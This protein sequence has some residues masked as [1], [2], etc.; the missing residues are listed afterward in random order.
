ML[1]K[2]T[3]LSPRLLLVRRAEQAPLSSGSD[4]V[5]NI[6]VPWFAGCNLKVIMVESD[7][8][9]I[10]VHEFLNVWKLTRL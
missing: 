7:S 6:E 9:Y 2:P 8:P 5:L 4:L 10:S 1:N 3:E